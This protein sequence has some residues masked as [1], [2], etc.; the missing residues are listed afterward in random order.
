MALKPLVVI[1][2]LVAASFSFLLGYDIGIMS[3]AKRLVARDLKLNSVEVEVLVGILNIVSGFGG[4][5]SGRLADASGRRCTVG[6]ACVVCVVGSLL[7]A[8]ASSYPAL[9]VGR[10]ITGFGI[11]SAFQVSPL[12]IAEV[13]PKS[14]RGRLVSCFDLFINSAPTTH[15]HTHPQQPSSKQRCTFP[16]ALCNT[17]HYNRSRHPRRLHRGL[18][19]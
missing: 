4:L 1:C 15:C 9:L 14:L 3:G 17:I 6:L 16:A 12:Y 5:A 7:M 11:G 19:L 2:V 18:R 8:I 13:A 10:V